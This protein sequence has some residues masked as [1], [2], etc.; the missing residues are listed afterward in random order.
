MWL[1]WS[2]FLRLSQVYHIISQTRGDNNE[3]DVM[4]E[5]IRSNILKLSWYPIIIIVCWIPSAV[6]DLR[7]AYNSYHDSFSTESDYLNLLPALKGFFTAIAFLT[8]T[9]AGG[10]GVSEIKCEPLRLEESS[11]G[12][13]E[14]SDDEGVRES[15]LYE[16][17][18]S[19][20]ES[21]PSSRP[22]LYHS[23]SSMDESSSNMLRCSFP[24]DAAV[25][26][27]DSVDSF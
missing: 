16:Q 19:E 27:K 8:T 24:S 2:I 15:L 18:K 12:D 4:A 5:K 14:G 11:T 22:S 23:D 1:L 21:F 17:F 9:Y 3:S 6:Y 7:E 10:I 13:D 26:R 25:I 20:E